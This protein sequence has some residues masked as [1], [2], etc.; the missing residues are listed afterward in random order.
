MF[1][2]SA[3][4]KAGWP[5]H[6]ALSSQTAACRHHAWAGLHRSLTNRCRSPHR[7]PLGRCLH[8][9][10]HSQSFSL[11]SAPGLLC[12]RAAWSFGRC[13]RQEGAAFSRLLPVRLRRDLVPKRRPPWNSPE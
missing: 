7:R 5:D 8:S 11:L 13:S 4:A 9:D 2:S 6:D 3:G 12:L 10:S 1:L